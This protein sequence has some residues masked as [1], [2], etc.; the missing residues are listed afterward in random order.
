MRNSIE[1]R[2]GLFVVAT[3]TLFIVFLFLLGDY[4]FGKG[5]KLYADFH[6]SGSL[7]AGAPVKISGVRIG[8]VTEVRYVAAAKNIDPPLYPEPPERAIQVRATVLIDEA[9]VEAVNSN[10]AFLIN[11]P[12]LF[13]ESYLELKRGENG[14]PVRSGTLFRGRDAQRLD[15]LISTITSAVSD[16]KLDQIDLKAIGILLQDGTSLIVTAQRILAAAEPEVPR[17]LNNANSAISSVKQLADNGKELVAANSDLA[18]TLH[19]TNVISG[20][21][22]GD[23]EN[24]LTEAHE[25]LGA[26]KKIDSLAGAVNPE[27]IAR[28]IDSAEITMNNLQGGSRDLAAIVGKVR[29]GQ[30]TVGALLMSQELYNDLK[31]FIR[32]IKRHPWKV[33]WRK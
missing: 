16:L 11:Q 24:L 2:V 17:L 15:T 3:V 18:R 20:K 27:K 25:A 12:G 29:S 32:D 5:L 26:V 21:L 23:S 28:I 9:Y 14:Q 13:G 33:L 31:D 6:F 7:S 19:N 1:V 22:A 10:S 30:S 4:R 8:K